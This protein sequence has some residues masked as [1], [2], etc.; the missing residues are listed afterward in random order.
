MQTFWV[1]F[2]RSTYGLRFSAI[3]QRQI[4]AALSFTLS[5]LGKN[6]PRILFPLS[7]RGNTG[8]AFFFFF[9]FF[10]GF[11][12]CI[13]STASSAAPQIPLCRRMLG[14][15]PGLL[16]LVHWQ[17]ATVQQRQILF[18]AF[19]YGIKQRQILAAHSFFLHPLN[20]VGEFFLDVDLGICLLEVFLSKPEQNNGREQSIL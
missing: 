5:S 7:R 8:P 19:F 17:S 10:L 6:C 3:K 16:Q 2:R 4:L 18:R 14:S 15:N 20:L 1:N 9:F 13:F 11:F 12:S